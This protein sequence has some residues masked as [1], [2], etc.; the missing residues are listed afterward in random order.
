MSLNKALICCLFCCTVCL[1]AL[2]IPLLLKDGDLDIPLEGVT[3]S[4]Q[5]IPQTD[6][7]TD[8][9]GRALLS[10]PEDASFP[11]PIIC[12]TPGYADTEIIIKN[13]S[14]TYTQEKPLVI[15][16]GL[17]TILEGEELVVQASRKG[18]TDEKSGVSIVRTSEEMKTTAQIGVVE[19]IMSSVSLLPGVGFKMGM[20]MEPSIRGGYPAEMGVTFDGVYLLEPFYWDGMVSI[21]S[22]YMVDSVKL[23]TGI[24]SSRY[25]QGTSGLLDTTSVKIGDA[26]K[27]T[28]NISTISADIVSEIPLGDKNDV[29]LYAHVTDLTTVKWA[30]TGIISIYD[31]FDNKEPKADFF[32]DIKTAVLPAIQYMPH[33][34]SVYG[35]WDFNPVPEFSL[36]ANI[37]CAYD[38]ASIRF[39]DESVNF[40]LD[41]PNNPVYFSRYPPFTS[42]DQWKYDDFQGMAGISCNWLLSNTMLLHGQLSYTAHS[43]VQHDHAFY[44]S[45]IY[46]GYIPV[47]DENGNSVYDDEGNALT[48]FSVTYVN[49]DSV[50][51]KTSFKQQM[52][53][54]IFSEIQIADSSIIS[55]GIE[56]V[57]K[58]RKIETDIY[59]QTAYSQVIDDT[60]IPIQGPEIKDFTSVPGNNILNSCAFAL[61]NFGT[62]TSVLQGEAGIRGEHYYLWN[63]EAGFNINN[64]PV[65]NPRAT[66]IYTP[67]RNTGVFDAVSFSAG[68]GLYSALSREASEIQ[69]SAVTDTFKLTPDTAWTSVIGT[70]ADFQN[71][72]RITFEGYYKHYLS[73]TYVYA[74]ERDGQNIIYYTENNGKGFAA[75]ADIMIEKSLNGWLDGYISYSFL[76]AR[77]YNPAVSQYDSQ[78]TT[79]GD[80]LGR[81]YYPEYHRFHTVNTVL[82]FRLPKDSTFT[83]AGSCAAGNPRKQYIDK[84]EEYLAGTYYDPGLNEYLF[85]A[86]Y[87]DTERN[88]PDWTVDIRFSKKGTF[89]NPKHTW[90]WY[91]G[92]ENLLGLPYALYKVENFKK[93][94]GFF[95]STGWTIGEGR[96]TI[97]MGLIPIPSFG[98]KIMF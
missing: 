52:Q 95:E 60:N 93:V 68:S 85:L 10:V 13:S 82:N 83:I 71:G 73:R 43:V 31:I 91:I 19:D 8:A 2:E 88:L 5:N 96:Y 63:K 92:I 74:D 23:S 22:P 48:E 59:K 12:V 97:D 33:I 34:Y 9:D 53:G 75:G 46:N 66:V 20:N 38:G 84:S 78:R 77:F 14:D 11:L 25:G 98:V 30:M 28:F 54:K 69:K 67:F 32:H 86:L 50:T 56:E 26:K 41:D 37:L 89:K 61:W 80:P 79:T 62:D 44:L 4:V 39:T 45:Q 36:T 72:I 65:V 42:I 3:V 51:K 49:E 6:S 18:K 17:D 90:E 35:K 24:F 1:Y 7:I 70:A 64:Y 29:F 27:L 21:L 55:I 57:F 16:M 81:W 58:T 94:D 40:Q 87:S 15:I 76:H 47:Y